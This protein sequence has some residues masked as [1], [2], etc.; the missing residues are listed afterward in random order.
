MFTLYRYLQYPYLH[1][2]LIHWKFSF[3]SILSL[4]LW[5][6][7]KWRHIITSEGPQAVLQLLPITHFALYLTRLQWMKEPIGVR[8]RWESA[9]ALES[10]ILCRTTWSFYGSFLVLRTDAITKCRVIQKIEKT[11]NISTHTAK[12]KRTNRP[13]LREVNR[14]AIHCLHISHNT[15]C[16]PPPPT[17]PP[18][19]HPKRNWR[20]CLCAIL[21]GNR[22]VLYNE[23]NEKC[24]NGE[25]IDRIRELEK[26]TEHAY[27]CLP[28]KFWIHY[29]MVHSA[30][31]AA[32]TMR[33]RFLELSLL[34]LIAEY[35]QS[36]NIL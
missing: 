11:L 8:G 27:K 5:P 4:G 9:Q 36:S 25:S 21:G 15:P 26:C 7:V 6:P 1:N 17:P 3:R 19:P 35:C 14:G 28:L 29:R 24:A 12:Q 31:G 10:L 22:G 20:Q 32:V 2:Y 23:S 30:R 33:W 18:T 13:N 34:I 16:C